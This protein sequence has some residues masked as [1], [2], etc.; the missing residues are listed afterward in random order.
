MCLV[1]IVIPIYKENLSYE[2]NLSL[3]QVWKILGH[4]PITYIAPERMRPFFKK[5][6]SVAEYFSDNNFD[7]VKAYSNLLLSSD[8]YHRFD[9]C[10]FILIYQLDGFI[11]ADRLQEFCDM[12]FDYIG[13]PVPRV[14]WPGMQGYVGNGGVSLRKIKSFCRVLSYINPYDIMLHFHRNLCTAEDVFWAWCGANKEI[15]F[16]VPDIRVAA[17][18]CIDADVMHHYRNLRTNLPFACHGWM[19]SDYNFW[20]NI[21]ES[22]GY[23][24]PIRHDN[25]LIP[26]KQIWIGEYL[27]ERLMRGL[28]TDVCGVIRK[29]LKKRYAIWGTGMDGGKCFDFLKILKIEVMCFFDK[30]ASEKCRFHDILVN[31]PAKSSLEPYKYQLIIATMR[32][33]NEICNQLISMGWDRNMFLTWRDIMYMVKTTYVNSHF[34]A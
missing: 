15:D 17:R 8:F 26:M 27:M 18:F 3:Q 21:I 31:F 9:D 11:F 24:L 19:Q 34:K 7:S 20:K 30:S 22:F 12:S 16:S 5:R 28:G 14:G 13:A 6:R 4:Y 1:K 2:E 33:E 25:T 23:E 32:Y 10:E 29:L